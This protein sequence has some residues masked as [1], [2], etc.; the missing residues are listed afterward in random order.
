MHTDKCDL[1]SSLD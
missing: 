1:L